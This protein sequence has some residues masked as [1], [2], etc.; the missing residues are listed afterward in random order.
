MF[1]ITNIPDVKDINETYSN[2]G[3]ASSVIHKTSTFV[4]FKTVGY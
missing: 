3:A 2:Q 4:P 1:N